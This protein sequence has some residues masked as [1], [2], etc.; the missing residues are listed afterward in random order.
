MEGLRV[1]LA[2]SFFGLAGLGLYFFSYDEVG[3]TVTDAELVPMG[4]GFML[5]AKIENTGGADRLTGV[6]SDAAGSVMLMGSGADGLAIP[7]ES[8]PGLSGD[9]VHAMLSGI[10]GGNDEGRLVPVSF[11]FERAGKI[12]TRARIDTA[13]MDHGTSYSVPDGEAM[14]D[15]FITA[16]PQGHGWKIEVITGGFTFS[17]EAVDGPHQPGVGHGHLYLNG[18]KL[19]RIYEPEVFI[20]ALPT[21]TH[22]VRVTLNTNDHRAYNVGDALVTAVAEIVVK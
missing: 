22:Q 7:A 18:L 6:A 12:T 15:V 16:K 4:D 19:Q 14:P 11:W 5:T 3:V 1:L 20:G 13:D 2:A 17:K 21:G 9:G 10:I 8:T